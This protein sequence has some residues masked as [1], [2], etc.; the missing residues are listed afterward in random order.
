MP[1][2]G[3]KTRIAVIGDSFVEAR[4]VRY[5]DSMAEKL[6]RLL[7]EEEFEVYRFGIS[8]AS[9]SQYLH[10]LRQEVAR[11]SP[12]VVVVVLIH[13]DFTDS[14]RFKAGVYS[15]SFL[16]LQVEDGVVARDIPPETYEK[17]WY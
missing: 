15:S 10:L 8:G 6:E 11:Y 16:K 17:R 1:E 2:R 13:N 5:D 3:P 12:D 9:L 4:Q 14:Y 7:G